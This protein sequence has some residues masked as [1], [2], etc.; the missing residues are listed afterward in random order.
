MLNKYQIGQSRGESTAILS[1]LGKQIL[2]AAKTLG[3]HVTL[4]KAPV[5]AGPASSEAASAGQ[6][7]AKSRSTLNTTA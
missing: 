2:A 1:N 3:Q 5:V 7:A 4:P 6:A